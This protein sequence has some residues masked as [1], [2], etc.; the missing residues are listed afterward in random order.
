MTVASILCP[1]E[2]ASGMNGFTNAR[3]IHVQ[4]VLHVL[5]QQHRAVAQAGRHNDLGGPPLG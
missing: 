5:R 4:P 2:A 3:A 1:G